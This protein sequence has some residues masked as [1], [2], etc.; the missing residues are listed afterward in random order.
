MDT[1]KNG[2]AASQ[3]A[4]QPFQLEEYYSPEDVAGKGVA[5]KQT[6]AKWRHMNRGP[7]YIKSGSRVLYRGKDLID[8]LTAQRVA[9][10]A[11]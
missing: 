2:A 8:W 4:D 6:L 3:V 9:P 1:V 10:E 5:A 11:V 7:A